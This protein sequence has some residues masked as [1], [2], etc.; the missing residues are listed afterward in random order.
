MES[1]LEKL[2]ESMPAIAE[3]IT[4]TTFQGA[5]IGL[6]LGFAVSRK[7]A[8]LSLGAGLGFGISFNKSNLYLRQLRYNLQN[9]Q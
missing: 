2:D 6:V 4:K 8:L 7:L 3:Y 9:H 5:S 1:R